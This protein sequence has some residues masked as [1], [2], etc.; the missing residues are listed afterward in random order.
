M[1]LSFIKHFFI[2]NKNKKRD[3][4]LASSISKTALII[5]FR[6]FNGKKGYKCVNYF[7]SH[8][9]I[10]LITFKGSPYQFRLSAGSHKHLSS[11]TNLKH[12]D[13]YMARLN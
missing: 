7:D 2:Q 9:L 11:E 6:C 3:C 8:C 10:K 12:V 1:L 4:L 13:R 5:H